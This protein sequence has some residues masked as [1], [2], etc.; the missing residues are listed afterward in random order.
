MKSLFTMVLLLISTL[1]AKGQT[2]INIKDYETR[3]MQEDLAMYV[4]PQFAEVVRIFSFKNEKNETVIRDLYLDG[5]I[6]GEAPQLNGVPYGRYVGYYRSGNVRDSG[7][8]VDG[9]RSGTWKTFYENG[10]VKDV[11]AFFNGRLHGI[12]KEYDSLGGL[13]SEC[14]YQ[15]GMPVGT[16]LWYHSGTTR[17][18]TQKPYID[19]KVH[20]EYKVFYKGGKLK[21]F[22]K[23]EKGNLVK[24]SE[25]LYDENGN[26]VPYRP[27]SVY[28]LPE[29]DLME[30]LFSQIRYPENAL[31]NKI[32][33]EV[34]VFLEVDKSG[35]I[36]KAT[37]LKGINK[38][39]NAEALRLVN[40]MKWKSCV[41]DDEPSKCGTIVDV[42]FYISEKRKEMFREEQKKKWK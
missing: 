8:Y 3:W 29:T 2:Q 33:G 19:G 11:D 34:S 39:C 15:K 37:I 26:E 6:R 22:E 12:I 9:V 27:M 20:G 41:I 30:Y 23:Y 13:L 7:F 36:T 1:V 5:H 14:R 4:K 18:K 25:K 10:A 24:G 28:I 17:V 32:Q 21:R 35:N 16:G 42:P 31:A 38:E 40:G